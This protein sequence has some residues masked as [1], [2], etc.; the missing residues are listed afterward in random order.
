M[1]KKKGIRL[2]CNLWFII[3]FRIEE[4]WYLKTAQAGCLLNNV[5]F[6]T[7]LSKLRKAWLKFP[8]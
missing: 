6:Y 5:Q 8:D 3:P 1:S 4:N 7:L 2:K